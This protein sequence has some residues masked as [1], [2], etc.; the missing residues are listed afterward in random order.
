MTNDKITVSRELLRQTI[1]LLDDMLAPGATFSTDALRAALEQPGVE[2]E[3]HDAKCP[4]LDGGA[5][6]CAESRSF[7]DKPW[8]RFCGAFGRGP[9]APYPGMIEAFEAHYS[10]SFTDREWHNET[11]VWAAAWKKAKAHQPP[12]PQQPVVEPVAWYDGRKFYATPSAAHMDCADIKALRPLYEA[13]QA[14][15]PEPVQEPVPLLSDEEIGALVREASK[16]GVLNRD[17]STSHR[18]A[19]AIEQAVRRNAGLK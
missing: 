16:G 12:Q 11:A 2:P 17:G 8:A 6:G 15:Q 14:Q 10:Q 5:C 3:I 1:D 18:I 4:A 9:D 13:P 19:R 7:I